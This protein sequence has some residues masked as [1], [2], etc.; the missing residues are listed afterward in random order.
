[1]QN[2]VNANIIKGLYRDGSFSPPDLPGLTWWMDASDESTINGGGGVSNDDP[3]SNWDD[4]SGEANDTEQLT[5]SR[6]ILWKSSG[7]GSNNMPHMNGDGSNDNIKAAT[8]I[9]DLTEDYTFYVVCASDVTGSDK[10]VL[11][12]LTTGVGVFTRYISPTSFRVFTGGGAAL[13]FNIGLHTTPMI[14][15]WTFNS[16]THELHAWVNGVDKGTS[17]GGASTS[18]G[19][20]MT[21]FAL[22]SDAI[23]LNG[24]VAEINYYKGF[25]H[26]NDQRADVRGYLNDKWGVFV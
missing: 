4:K 10:A 24:D 3:V 23:P 13:D 8:S 5:A 26:S 19:G 22:P 16:V 9:V 12:T 6:Q 25:M 14:L 21:V 15:V 17:I 7:F 1:M 20:V 11:S 18:H 2:N